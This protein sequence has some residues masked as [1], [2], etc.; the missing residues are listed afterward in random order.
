[1]SWNY[2]Q[3]WPNGAGSYM[4]D[5]DGCPLMNYD[6]VKQA[7]AGTGKPD[8]KYPSLLYDAA[9]GIAAQLVL[10]SDAP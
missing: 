7:L 1:M 10:V 8:V 5:Y 2:N 9:E 4:V 3:P 6:F